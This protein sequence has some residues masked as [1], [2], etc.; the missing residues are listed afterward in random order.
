MKIVTQTR[1]GLFWAC[2]F[3]ICCGF[4]FDST[5]GASH[6]NKK[7]SFQTPSNGFTIRFVEGNMTH[8]R[9]ITRTWPTLKP[10][11]QKKCTHAPFNINYVLTRGPWSR[12]NSENPYSTI[13]AMRPMPRRIAW[14]EREVCVSLSRQNIGNTVLACLP[15]LVKPTKGNR[16]GTRR[17]TD[18]WLVSDMQVLM[19]RLPD[20]LRALHEQADI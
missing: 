5:G 3:C 14:R 11:P 10:P 13:I 19:T 6:S 12:T 1:S 2:L 18:T 17:S 7:H 20:Y 15:N 9:P 4:L 16:Q 8:L